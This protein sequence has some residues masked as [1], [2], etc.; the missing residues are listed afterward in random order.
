MF[1]IV[2]KIKPICNDIIH[3]INGGKYMNYLVN[4]QENSTKYLKRFKIDNY[5]QWCSVCVIH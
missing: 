4:K 5:E 2:I 1:F 3:Q